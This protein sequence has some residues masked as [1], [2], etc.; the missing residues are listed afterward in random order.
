MDH[1]ALLVG[2][3][4][5]AACYKDPGATRT[6]PRSPDN[7]VAVKGPDYSATLADPV[8]FLPVDSEL[9]LALDVDSLRK[10]PLWPQLAGKLSQ[11]TGPA[12]RQFQEA[13]GFDPM[14]TIHAI[15]IGFKNLKQETPDGVIVVSGLDRPKLMGCIGKV[16]PKP[17]STESVVVD[18]DVILA[19][20]SNGG[21]SAFAFVDASTIVGAIGANVGKPQLMAVLSAGAPLH[22]SPAFAELLK[23]TDLEASLWTVMNG[24]SSIFDQATGALGMRP[25]A[26]FGSVNL[27]AGLTM[28]V[29]MRLDSA[30]Q[31]QQ[32]QQM[33]SGQI[34]MARAMFDKLDIT[35]DNADL[36][37]TLAMTEQQLNNI[38]QMV[39]GAVGGP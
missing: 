23:L 6:G 24:S 21:K 35:T 1:R 18:G 3:L 25:K 14:T 37:V 36:V 12:L 13:C 32:L 19:T 27:T 34:G 31:A 30:A 9:V 20:S 17:G 8:G 26:V 29:R 4:L 39:L 11:A 16:K 7:A 5:F 33:V 22:T 15:T 10:S 28:N 2:S 38:M